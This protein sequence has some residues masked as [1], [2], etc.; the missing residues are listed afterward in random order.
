M[1]TRK[2]S[3]VIAVKFVGA[4]M[5]FAFDLP[6]GTLTPLYAQETKPKAKKL[7][8]RETTTLQTKDGVQLRCDFY[9][10]TNGKET[11]PVMLLHGWEGPRG[12][13]NSTDFEGLALY[14]Q[15]AGHAVLVPT[16]RGH[17]GSTQ[18]ETVA[19]VVEFDR[20][21]MGGADLAAM[22]RFDLEAAKKFLV[23]KHN[24]EQLNI[25]MLCVV[26]AEMGRGRRNQLDSS[27]LELAQSA[28]LEAR[29]RREGDGADFAVSI[30]Q[31]VSDSTSAGSSRNSKSDFRDDCL[32]PKSTQ[33]C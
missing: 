25:E 7:P 17:P 33:G 23:K 30:V 13:G 20:E 5:F 2:Q 14:L 3:S 4:L 21:K 1:N 22:V 9:P 28:R 26:G 19:G 12:Q 16:F 10:G 15:R 32:R 6:G 27:R 29:A 18:V 11:V 24:E 31:R 8:P